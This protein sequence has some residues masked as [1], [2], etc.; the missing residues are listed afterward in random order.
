MPSDNESNATPAFRIHSVVVLLEDTR[1]IIVLVNSRAKACGSAA[2]KMCSAI[3]P[4]RCR[5]EGSRGCEPQSQMLRGDDGSRRRPLDPGETALLRGDCRR[6]IWAGKIFR[7]VLRSAARNQQR[8][9]RAPEAC[10]SPRHGNSAI[11]FKSILAYAPKQRS[12]L[13]GGVA[14]SHTNARRTG[15]NLDR[16]SFNKMASQSVK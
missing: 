2:S 3:C 4:H 8:S 9:G 11:S 6:D 13:H 14:A 10:H 5:A 1:C 12:R 16:T 7:G 15:K